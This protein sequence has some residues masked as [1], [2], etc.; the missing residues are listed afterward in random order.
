MNYICRYMKMK[1]L[2]ELQKKIDNLNASIFI[3]W[4]KTISPFHQIH[5][6]GIY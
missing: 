5:I 4:I 3:S 2:I 1:E 6:E